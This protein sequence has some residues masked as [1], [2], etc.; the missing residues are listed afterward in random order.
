LRKDNQE[1]HMSNID[2][3]VIGYFAVHPP[4]NV[5]CDGDACIIA[6]TQSAL[7]RYIKSLSEN[8]VIFEKRKTRLKEILEGMSMGGSYAFDEASYKR[9]YPLANRRGFNLG[10]EEFP[11]TETGKHFVVVGS[12]IT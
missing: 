8:E 6:G 12:S 9:F 2:M 5:L 7:N 10:R 3:T 4:Q 11:P 1:D